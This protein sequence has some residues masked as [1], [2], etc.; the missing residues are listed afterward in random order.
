MGNAY[1]AV[2]RVRKLSNFRNTPNRT[3]RIVSPPEM[4][5]GKA[6]M[7]K[8]AIGKTSANDPLI[9]SKQKLAYLS[10][11]LAPQGRFQKMEPGMEKLRAQGLMATLDEVQ[12][13]Q[14]SLKSSIV[15]ESLRAR[16]LSQY[17]CATKTLH[18]ANIIHKVQIR[19]RNCNMQGIW[20]FIDCSTIGIFMAP[21]LLKRLE[22]SRE[23]ANITTLG[24]HGRVMQ[25]G[26][27]SQKMRMT[28]Q[29]SDFLAPVN[30]SD[31][32][33]VLM[34]AYDLVLGL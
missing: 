9:L 28:I 26:K 21:R 7:A 23:A 17:L 2:A 10:R 18:S 6:H 30:E 29:Y 31:V 19:D 15:L 11:Y 12:P 4:T 20:A 27:D 14:I 8:A 32:Q 25:H 16:M 5:M 33:D 1:G 22:I 34:Y 13:H 24:L 3:T